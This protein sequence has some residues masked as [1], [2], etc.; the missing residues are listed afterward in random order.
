M[1]GYNELYNKVPAESISRSTSRDDPKNGHIDVPI[2]VSSSLENMVKPKE[3]TALKQ[4]ASSE[5]EN[6]FAAMATLEPGL[7]E[8]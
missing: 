3:I 5:R 2:T 8:N 4:A 7:N 1:L 6:K